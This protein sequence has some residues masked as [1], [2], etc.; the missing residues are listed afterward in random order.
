MPP[1]KKLIHV[2]TDGESYG[3]H[4]RHGDMALAYCLDYI[5][6]NELA[7]LTN[8]A[9]FIDLV[10]P[11]WEVEIYENSSWSCAHGIERWRSNCGCNSGMHPSWNQDWRSPLR[12][13]LDWLNEKLA[14]VY[15]KEIGRY[16]LDPWNARNNYVEVVL[17]R[18]EATLNAFIAKNCKIRSCWFRTIANFSFFFLCLAAQSDKEE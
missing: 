8:Y 13:S 14:S 11:T 16:M 17:N 4:H 10:P 6:Q 12:N 5:E 2:A 18:S 3:H 1:G 9:Q 15:E 7:T